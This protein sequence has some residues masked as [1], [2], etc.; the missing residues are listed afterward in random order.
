VRWR[1]YSNS[2]V[3]SCLTSKDRGHGL[4]LAPGQLVFQLVQ[5][6]RCEQETSRFRPKR[7]SVYRLRSDCQKPKSTG[8]GKERGRTTETRKA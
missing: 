1:R 3:S 8:F 6:F 5:A 2:D 7:I 4:T